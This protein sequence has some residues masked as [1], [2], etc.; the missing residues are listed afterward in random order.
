MTIAYLC[1]VISTFIPICCAGYAKFS[2][3]GYNNRSPREFL[4]S[5]EGAGKRANFAQQNFYETFPA[6]AVGVVVAHLMEAA[7]WKID[8]AAVI[9]VTGR[10]LYAVLYITDQHMLRSTAWAVAFGA[11]IALYFIGA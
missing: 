3:K 1:I 11:T 9:Y 5:L 6:F 2:T 10:V 7:Q 8:F 4:A